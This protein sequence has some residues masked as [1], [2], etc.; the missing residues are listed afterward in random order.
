MVT[1]ANPPEAVATTRPAE[2]RT[3]AE[4]EQWFEEAL[5]TVSD[6][7]APTPSPEPP[8]AAAVPATD[9][10]PADPPTAESRDS[11]DRGTGRRC[12]THCQPTADCTGPLD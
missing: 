5:A 4:A 8:V 2:S 9:A 6:A 7:P 12:N 10:P 3:E 11:P 1:E